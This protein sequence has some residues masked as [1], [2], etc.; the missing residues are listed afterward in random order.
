MAFTSCNIYLIREHHVYGM[1]LIS[2]KILVPA[3]IGLEMEYDVYGMSSSRCDLSV[4][5]GAPAGGCAWLWSAPIVCNELQSTYYGI[6][7]CI[8]S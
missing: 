3:E 4:L 1:S 7:Y 8:L 5:P 2:C 6:K